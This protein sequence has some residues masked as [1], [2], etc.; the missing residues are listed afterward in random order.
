MLIADIVFNQVRGNITN[1][2]VAVAAPHEPSGDF[3]LP[4]DTL[5]IVTSGVRFLAG[6]VH[7]NLSSFMERNGDLGGIKVAAW[8]PYRVSK[9][10]WVASSSVIFALGPSEENRILWY[11][12]Q[13]W[14]ELPH[15]AAQ[16]E[17][18]RPRDVV[19]TT[20]GYGA[21][22]PFPTMLTTTGHLSFYPVY[23]MLSSTATLFGTMDDSYD[24][25]RG[26]ASLG[27]VIQK[28]PRVIVPHTHKLC[29][30]FGSK[31]SNRSW[32]SWNRRQENAKL[33]YAEKPW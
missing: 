27:V 21:I 31:N 2:T 20:H 7:G 13:A 14:E 17:A 32:H 33:R 4:M 11:D 3:Q 12:C 6:E 29:I 9:W 30:T 25:S 19:E 8:K 5:E 24:L 10:S 22:Y 23:Q 1:T 18:Y 15:G 16:L 28:A 26:W